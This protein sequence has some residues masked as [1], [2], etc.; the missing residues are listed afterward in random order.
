M[1][2]MNL[3]ISAYRHFAFLLLIMFFSCVDKEPTLIL[4]P[5]TTALADIL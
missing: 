4:L 2:T 5:D 3:I 1:N